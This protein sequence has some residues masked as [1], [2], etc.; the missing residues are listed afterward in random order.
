MATATARDLSPSRA[1]DQTE[2][3]PDLAKGSV[4]TF[5][6]ETSKKKDSGQFVPLVSRAVE[7]PN[8]APPKELNKERKK[9]KSAR[10]AAGFFLVCKLLI[11]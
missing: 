8:P 4:P 1:K 7:K 9:T 3:R 10:E 5:K 6:R 2:T 11:P